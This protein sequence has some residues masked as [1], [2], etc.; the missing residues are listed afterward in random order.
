MKWLYLQ[1]EAP[2]AP[3]DSQQSQQEKD[4]AARKNKSEILPYFQAALNR[5]LTCYIIPVQMHLPKFFINQYNFVKAA[6]DARS[7]KE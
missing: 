6:Y 4:E 3:G 5:I 2:S 7:N 1:E